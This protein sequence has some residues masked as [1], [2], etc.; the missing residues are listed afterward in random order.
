MSYQRIIAKTAIA[1]R[2]IEFAAV[3][4][5]R[6]LPFSAGFSRH[7]CLYEIRL[8]IEAMSVPSPPMFVPTISART[9]SVKA[10]SSIAQGTLLIIWLAGAG[11]R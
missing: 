11:R 10:E 4:Q 9:L 7:I 8:A 3:K 6:Y 1:S 5:A 2:N